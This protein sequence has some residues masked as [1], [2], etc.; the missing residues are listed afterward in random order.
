MDY[1]CYYYFSCCFFVERFVFPSLIRA[2]FILCSLA[3]PSPFL[4][5]LFVM[6]ISRGPSDIAP[7][8]LL[9]SSPAHKPICI[10]MPTHTG[11]RGEQF[12]KLTPFLESYCSPWT[13]L[14]QFR[15]PCAVIRCLLIFSLVYLLTCGWSCSCIKSCYT[16]GTLPFLSALG[17]PLL[18]VLSQTPHCCRRVTL[19]RE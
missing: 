14:P 3:L 15:V 16:K 4:V 6:R 2:F 12:I 19:Q 13:P 5:L 10:H 8:Y 17:L 7:R 9:L 18:F 11:Y 1:G